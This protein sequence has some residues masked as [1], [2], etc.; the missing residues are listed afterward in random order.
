MAGPAAKVSG[1]AARQGV[2]L[3][4]GRKRLCAGL[5]C[6][7]VRTLDSRTRPVYMLYAGDY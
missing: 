1:A 5:C 4:L 2:A 7:N 6:P 3:L